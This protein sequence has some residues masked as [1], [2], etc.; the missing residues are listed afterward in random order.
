M[1]G[2]VIKQEELFQERILKVVKEYKKLYDL[3]W[4]KYKIL[5]D[6]IKTLVDRLHEE[7][8]EF[9]KIGELKKLEEELLKARYYKLE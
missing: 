6:Y 9:D 2:R 5:E 7:D 8:E 4:W 1:G 3:Y